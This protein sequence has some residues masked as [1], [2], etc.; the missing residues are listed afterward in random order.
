[1]FTHT[2]PCY[3]STLTYLPT[4]PPTPP[5]THTSHRCL[6]RGKNSPVIL[7]VALLDELS[8]IAAATDNP[9]L[10]FQPFAALLRTTAEVVVL[11]PRVA[12]ALR[13]KV[14][15][16]M[17]LR[18][19]VDELSVEELTAAQ[20]LAFKEQLVPSEWGCWEGGGGGRELGGKGG[21]AG[22]AGE[23]GKA[24]GGNQ[25]VCCKSVS[26]RVALVHGA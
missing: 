20:Y 15:S 6:E 16:W 8:A 25:V 22:R 26:A 21:T 7:P 11:G 10:M 2:L 19:M 4:L 18:F 5:P 14:G 3:V 17:Y 24:G 12:L 9:D 1:M 23:V 13:P